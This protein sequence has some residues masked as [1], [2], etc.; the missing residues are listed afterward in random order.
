[1]VLK[2]NALSLHAHHRSDMS[3]LGYDE[4]AKLNCIWF[5]NL[6]QNIGDR[7]MCSA[8][9]FQVFALL[10]RYAETL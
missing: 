3:G 1:M 4:F 10:R 2:V 7:I 6:Q 9:A 8:F 5:F